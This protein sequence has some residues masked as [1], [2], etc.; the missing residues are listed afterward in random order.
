MGNL[1]ASEMML[2]L[3]VLGLLLIPGVFFT[4]TLQNA[5]N[6]CAPSNRTMRPG[7]VW[8]L[9]VP[10]F[11]LVWQFI[12]VFR[13]SSSLA[14]EFRSRNMAREAE[15]GKTIGLAYCILGLCSIIPVVGMLTAIAGLICLIIYW[16]KIA[17]FSA[18]IA[19]PPSGVPAV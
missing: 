19:A 14:N 2:I 1:G 12:V 15:P 11:S 9:W 13:I 3:V 8:L 6:R 4:L 7:Q 17:G 16:V 18:E 10:L 5:L